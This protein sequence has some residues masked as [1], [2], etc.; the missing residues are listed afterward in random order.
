MGP[1]ILEVSALVY[2]LAPAQELLR[3]R[4]GVGQQVGVR[5]EIRQATAR[6]DRRIHTKPASRISP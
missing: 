2:M 5:P 4:A 6:A 3:P 1:Q